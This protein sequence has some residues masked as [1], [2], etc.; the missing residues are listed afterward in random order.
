MVPALVVGCGIHFFPFS[1]RWLALANRNEESLECLAKLRRLPVTDE[2]V[3]L[4]WRGILTEDR[5][6]KQM[7]SKEHPDATGLIMELKQWFDLFRPRYIR[8]TFVAMAIPFFQQ[9]CFILPSLAFRCM[10][11]RLQ[12]RK[13]K[14]KTDLNVVVLRYQCFCILRTNLF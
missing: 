14:M 9:V 4:E 3:Q 12:K 2:T 6:Q 5:F 13:K 11:W 7:L 10:P 1:P 8:R